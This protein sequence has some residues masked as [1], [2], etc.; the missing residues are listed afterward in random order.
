MHPCGDLPEAEAVQASARS[1][2]SYLLPLRLSL[3]QDLEVL[4][5]SRPNHLKAEIVASL[6]TGLSP[7]THAELGFVKNRSLGWQTALYFL[8]RRSE[9]LGVLLSD[10]HWKVERLKGP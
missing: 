3:K 4:H 9:S 8:H 1:H 7:T 5:C 6:P 2:G 10:E